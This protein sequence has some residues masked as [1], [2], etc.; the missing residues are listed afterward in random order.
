[1]FQGSLQFLQ[2]NQGKWLWDPC[3]SWV[4]E[5]VIVCAALPVSGGVT[6]H[7][8]L[9]H[10]QWLVYLVG[11]VYSI[12]VQV[13]V[14]QFSC[15]TPSLKDDGRP[16]IGGPDVS[17]MHHWVWTCFGRP[18]E[19]TGSPLNGSVMGTKLGY[20]TS[21]V[22]CQLVVVGCKQVGLPL[23]SN[24]LRNSFWTTQR[25]MMLPPVLVSTLQ[26]TVLS[27]VGPMS[28]GI[29]HGCQGLCHHVGVNVSDSDIFGVSS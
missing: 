8:W 26:H 1:M 14:A 20:G 3:W 19:W 22:G 11:W 12:Y 15:M 27:Q 16:S 4:E 13:C 29:C 9:S 21:I 28:A 18:W 7:L 24:Q 23:A 6:G 25:G 10:T 5:G 17:A 2:S